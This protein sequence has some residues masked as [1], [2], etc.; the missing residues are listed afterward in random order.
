LVAHSLGVREVG[1]SS[2]LAPIKFLRIPNMDSAF[3]V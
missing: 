2:L 3:D 1:S